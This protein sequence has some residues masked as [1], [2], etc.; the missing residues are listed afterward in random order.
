MAAGQEHWWLVHVAAWMQIAGF[1]VFGGAALYAFVL[2]PLWLWLRG[3]P[4]S[5]EVSVENIR[6]VMI[7]RGELR[8]NR[9]THRDYRR[10]AKP[11][12]PP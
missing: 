12:D 8:P 11:S 6:I 10:T 7:Q 9:G 3:K 5:E 4:K 2:G 1:V